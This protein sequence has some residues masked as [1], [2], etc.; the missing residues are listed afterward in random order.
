[1]PQEYGQRHRL[2]LGRRGLSLRMACPR[3]TGPGP[4]RA[5]RQRG[6]IMQRDPTRSRAGDR[7][8]VGSPVDTA[9]A[10]CGRGVSPGRSGRIRAAGRRGG[11]LPEGRVA[12]IRAGALFADQPGLVQ[13]L[14]RGL[15]VATPRDSGQREGDDPLVP[16]T[17]L[18]HAPFGALPGTQ[19]QDP[20]HCLGRRGV[21]RLAGRSPAGQRV[22]RDSDGPAGERISR[23]GRQRS[24][25]R[26]PEASD[27]ACR[28]ALRGNGK[29][30]RAHR[31]PGRR[32]DAQA[33]RHPRKGM[34]RRRASA[35]ATPHSKRRGG[36][37]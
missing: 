12:A 32:R 25:R 23:P 8:R 11:T 3:S 5:R 35:H 30:Q 15:A 27:G 36:R 2:V 19:T 17:A 18:R 9:L 10:P 14:L 26:G 34:G 7:N 22:A 16:D 37:T 29:R 1:M 4:A 31:G 28:P 21:P 20:R 33:R 13:R 24:L 6:R